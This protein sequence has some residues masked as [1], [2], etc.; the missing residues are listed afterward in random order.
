[1]IHFRQTKIHIFLTI[2]LFFFLSAALIQADHS[3]KD[4]R[5]FD[6]IRAQLDQLKQLSERLKG[7]EHELC[8]TLEPNPSHLN[9]DY[10]YNYSKMTFSHP[11][12]CIL[13]LAKLLNPSLV[14]QTALNS[15]ER[16]LREWPSTTPYVFLDHLDDLL[17]DPTRIN[18]L[19]F[20]LRDHFRDNLSKITKCGKLCSNFLC[21]LMSL[22]GILI[23]VLAI[24]LFA[25]QIRFQQQ[26][27]TTW[28]SAYLFLW[29]TNICLVVFIVS[30][31]KL[32]TTLV[33]ISAI[34]VYSLFL[35]LILHPEGKALIARSFVFFFGIITVMC[36]VTVFLSR[37]LSPG[38][39]EKNS[40][41]FP[42]WVVSEDTHICLDGELIQT[43]DRISRGSQRFPLNLG[44][45]FLHVAM[46]FFLSEKKISSL[47][48]YARQPVRVKD[49]TVRNR[50]R[51]TKLSALRW[52]RKLGLR[53]L[54]FGFNYFYYH[55]YD[56][57]KNA[58]LSETYK[59]DKYGIVILYFIF[60]LTAHEL[61]KYS[62][63]L[64]I[65]Y[66]IESLHPNHQNR[67]PSPGRL[68]QAQH[69]NQAQPVNQRIKILDRK[70]NA[71]KFQTRFWFFIRIAKV[72]MVAGIFMCNF[73]EQLEKRIGH[74]ILVLLFFHFH[75]ISCVERCIHNSKDLLTLYR[76]CIEPDSTPQPTQPL[77][78]AEP[79]Y[80][81]YLKNILVLGVILFLL[82]NAQLEYEYNKYLNHNDENVNILS[83][84][85]ELYL[86]CATIF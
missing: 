34:C 72:F 22:P 19:L 35:I 59:E 45:I 16:R 73:D 17:I 81:P 20:Q 75:L 58:L 29:F 2:L 52:V 9:L 50:E 40:I 53:I 74:I 36:L 11:I 32:G 25:L 68:N 39:A 64:R 6:E 4:E 8:T 77:A 27:E 69:N 28:S 21:S 55:L 43:L 67:P 1:M 5:L 79:N 18:E 65:Q 85:V 48:R 30:N 84:S 38:V 31:A 71:V 47:T 62:D 60:S 56:D 7:R 61:V 13:H 57:S 51:E 83:F 10:N 70:K 33:Y 14:N 24:S 44:F 3:V 15:L 46:S 78:T 66:V 80:L 12:H 49:L 54:F 37:F 23:A 76:D 41:V 86:L 63:D 42:K 26:L 82:C